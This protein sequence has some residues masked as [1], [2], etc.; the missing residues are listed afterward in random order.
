MGMT[1]DNANKLIGVSRGHYKCN[2]VVNE[3]LFGAKDNGMFARDYRTWG[4][5]TGTPD[6]GVVVVGSDGVHVGGFISKTEFVHSSYGR[7]QVVKDPIAK[8]RWVFPLG[9][10]F[11]KAN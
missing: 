2:Q 9:H 8:L 6:E 7:D 11:R 3:V 10:M 5:E 4:V 1:A